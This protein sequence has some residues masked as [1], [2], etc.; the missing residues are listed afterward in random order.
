MVFSAHTPVAGPDLDHTIWLRV[1]HRFNRQVPRTGMALSLRLRWRIGQRYLTWEGTPVRVDLPQ[2]AAPD[3]L[4]IQGQ[5]PFLL[6]KDKLVM[7]EVWAEGRDM[8]LLTQCPILTIED[9]QTNPAPLLG[10]TFDTACGSDTAYAVTPDLLGPADGPR[11]GLLTVS[12]LEQAQV[13]T[14]A[15]A[16]LL[17]LPSQISDCFAGL[18]IPPVEA[19]QSPGV[20]IHPAPPPHPAQPD[21]SK[22][23]RTSARG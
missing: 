16:P 5:P 20:T 13:E 17:A 6:P 12:G 7:L 1:E 8:R 4:A 2:G 11:L 19:D 22:L 9:C 15:S 21:V 14:G 3:W 10:W 18:A 23:R